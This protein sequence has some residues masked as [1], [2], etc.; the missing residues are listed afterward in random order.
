MKKLLVLFAAIGLTA[1]AGCEGPQGPPGVPGRTVEA[2]VFELRNVNFDYEPGIGYSIYGTLVPNIFDSDSVIM[3][4]LVDLIDSNTP[5]WQQI[6]RTL[7][8]EEGEVDYDFDFSKEDYQIYLG[9]T[10]FPIGS[11]FTTNQ[12]FRILILPG[13]FSKKVVD[14]SDYNAVIKAYGI[15]DSKVKQLQV[16]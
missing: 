9:G 3:Y 11:D 14:Y 13:Y 7:Y 10:F 5:V 1:L 2:E 6:P 16:K 8:L 15:D 12:T 4:R